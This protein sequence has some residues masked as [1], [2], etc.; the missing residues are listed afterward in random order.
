MPL[1]WF[2]LVNENRHQGSNSPS[3]LH[4][5]KGDEG[6]EVAVEIPFL[7][8]GSG[9]PLETAEAVRVAA[10]FGEGGGGGLLDGVQLGGAVRMFAD[11]SQGIAQGAEG[12]GEE[13]RGGEGG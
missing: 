9:L 2:V 13:G 5:R 12:A 1:V 7:F 4:G 10:V 3:I 11:E 8:F 6:G